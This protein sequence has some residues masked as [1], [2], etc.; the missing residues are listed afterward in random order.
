MQG[1]LPALD[2]LRT[3]AVLA[4]FVFHSA[5]LV[6]RGGAI[7]V[8]IF[9]VLSGFVITLLLLR[10]YEKQGRISLGRFYIM[11][12]A[13]LWPA[14]LLVCA[15]VICI[16]VIL[17]NGS[18]GGEIF[19]SLRAALY[20]TNIFRAIAAPDYNDYS[21]MAHTWSLAVEEQFYLVWPLVFILLM[22]MM[23]LRRAATTTLCLALLPV[24]LRFAIWDDGAGKNHIYNGVDTRADQLLVGCGLAMLLASLPPA[25]EALIRV[26]RIFRVGIWPAL[27]LLLL[28]CVAFPISRITGT[29]AGAYWTVGTL[30]VAAAAGL[31]IAGLATNSEHP[32]ARFLSVRWI[33]WTG[34]NLSYGIY[35]WHYPVLALMP[36]SIRASIRFPIALILTVGAAYLS[37][38][39][40]EMPVRKFARARF[41]NVTVPTTPSRPIK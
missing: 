11:R 12:L 35:L 17:P 10:E 26:S 15:V 14:L 2:G 32:L 33:A 16:A 21:S 20:T 25:S 7:G 38:R 31:L 5:T 22:K 1:R 4:V 28:V 37:Y 36:D 6:A 24:I 18:L 9:F 8:D 41:G 40:V 3:F 30:I 39:F 19:P 27:G 34:A 29:V 13:R 23:T